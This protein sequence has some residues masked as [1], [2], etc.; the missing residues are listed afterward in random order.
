MAGAG[1]HS[2]LWGIQYSAWLAQGAT[3][4]TDS[5]GSGSNFPLGFNDESN[6]YQLNQFYVVLERP[7]GQN[8]CGWDIGG[9]V[10]LLYGTDHRFTMARGLETEGDFSPKWNSEFYGLS[11]PQL[12][13]EVY[14]PILSGIH[15]KFGRFYT[16]IGYEVVTAP[17]NFFYSHTYSM[18]YGEPFTHTGFLGSTQWGPFTVHGGLTRG[19]D[20]WEDN[21]NDLGF[22]TGL[23]WT[24]ADERTS[25]AFAVHGGREQDEPPPNT[26]LRN[27]FSL[28]AEHQLNPWC[29]WVVQYDHGF[30]P[31]GAQNGRRDARWHGLTQ[32]LFYT[33][34]PHW[35]FG[36][37][38][39]WFRDR[40]GARID[41]VNIGGVDMFGVTAG[42]N[43]MPNDRVV[44][45]PSFR[46]DWTTTDGRQPFIDFTRHDQITL[47]MDFIVKF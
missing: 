5:P 24:S 36:L 34:N 46:W 33:I 18:L 2:W 13:A 20:N 43:Y 21:N 1:I 14:A 19:W 47:D 10:D 4:N 28:V 31:D 11:M 41:P 42:L 8:R 22:L 23:S 16:T 29:Q 7:T 9:R 27:V 15:M 26:K 35:K 6:A 39:E 40:D 30:E 45:R 25:I 12:Y 37:R 44:V 38:T 17:D 32:Y 3:I